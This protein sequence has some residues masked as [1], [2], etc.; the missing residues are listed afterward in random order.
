MSA[1]ATITKTDTTPI[2]YVQYHDGGVFGKRPVL[3]GKAARPTF[4]ELPRIDMR[5]LFSDKL[6]DRKQ[7][8]A[9]LGAACRDVGFFY[10]VNH[11]VDETLLDETF[12]AAKRYFNLPVDVKME[13]HNQKTKKFRGYE[14]FLEGKLDPSTR[15]GMSIRARNTFP[16]CSTMRSTSLRYEDDN[17][18][19]NT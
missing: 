9:E 12:D 2:Q 6:E 19:R 7:L 16:L 5:R 4:N 17:A 10:A 3:T 8:A 15:G 18:I 13:C 1:T 11:G 14:A